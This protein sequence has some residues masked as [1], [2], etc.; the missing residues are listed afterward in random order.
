MIGREAAQA[1]LQGYI[2]AWE[3]AEAIK[4][5]LRSVDACGGWIATRNRDDAHGRQLDRAIAAGQRVLAPL[6]RQPAAPSAAW[7]A[8]AYE[9]AK[10]N[11]KAARA[12]RPTVRQARLALTT[13]DLSVVHSSGRVDNRS[14]TRYVRPT[15]KTTRPRVSGPIKE[16]HRMSKPAEK[17]TGTGLMVKALEKLGKPAHH[18]VVAAEAI[19]LDKAQARKSGKLVWNGKTPEQT[20]SAA[21]TMSHVSGSGPFVRVAPGCF[22]LREWPAAKRR[23]SPAR[24]ETPKARAARV[25]KTQGRKRGV[26]AKRSTSAQPRQAVAA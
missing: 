7:L 22:A 1:A 5:G 10:A 12:D 3:D 25:V 21:M 8:G 26:P 23:R 24:P 4:Y 13:P 9:V 19:K 14:R 16:V 2:R 17:L 6:V 18:S 11:L 20:I 15:R